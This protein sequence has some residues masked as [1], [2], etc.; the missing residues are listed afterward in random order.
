MS[1]NNEHAI[2][3]IRDNILVSA[4]VHKNTDG[5]ADDYDESLYAD[6]YDESLYADES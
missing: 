3:M 2:D 6:D 4:H 5:Y 1:L